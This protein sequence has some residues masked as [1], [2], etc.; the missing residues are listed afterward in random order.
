[1]TEF[2]TCTTIFLQ[3]LFLLI[4]VIINELQGSQSACPLWHV[5]LKGKCY[6]A[7][8]LIGLIECD[9][10]RN[11][12]N[13]ANGMCLTWD[14]KTDSVHIS[15]CLFV[16]VDHTMCKMGS[17]EISTNVSGLELNKW[18]CGRLNRQG[19]QCMQC[20][21]GYGP[22]ALSDGVSCASCSKHRHLW[23]LNLL[24]Q[25][26]LLTVMFITILVLQI[27][28]TASPWNIIITYSQLVV[29]ALMYDISLNNDISCYIGNKVTV[30]FIITILGVSNLDFL[31]LVIP[32]LCISSSLK[33]INTLFFDYI[34]ALYPI[35]MTMLVYALIKLYDHNFKIVIVLSLPLQKLY[36]YFHG[37]WNPKQS[38]L[39]TFATFLLLSYSKLLFVSCNFLFA[40]Q[41]YNSTGNFVPDSTVLLHDPSVP[42]FKSKHI[43]Y[44]I[45]ALSAI[46]IF[47][48]LPPLFLLLY[49]TRLFKRLLTC[50][51]FQRWDI[52]H[53]IMDTFQ[54]WYKDGTEGTYDY[55]PLSALY[56]LLRIGLVGEFLTVIALS[57]HSNGYLKWLLTGYFHILLGTCFLIAKPYKKQWMNNVDGLI[58]IA[59]GIYCCLP[60]FPRAYR[61]H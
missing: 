40:V 34:V 33:A 31:R 44:I 1:M 27:K 58:L 30:K 54:G 17:Y 29:N 8:E 42:Y 19:A 50:C 56:M 36:H 59:I 48:L 53:M 2:K 15:Y 10:S 61:G 35:L 26:L 52:L 43:P 24:L 18:T 38:I 49:P 37:R 16:P 51:G 55:R 7:Q 9:S 3:N 45:L 57:P 28:G 60:L 13:I 12:L 21:S 6:C 46:T 25:L 39:S 32:P 22:A 47:I 4:V 14:G 5:E 11:A 23:I 20:I 41:S